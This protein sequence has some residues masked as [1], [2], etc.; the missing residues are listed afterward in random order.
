MLQNIVFNDSP[1][2][3]NVDFSEEDIATIDGI[4]INYLFGDGVDIIFGSVCLSCVNAVDDD[5][6]DCL[7][8]CCVCFHFFAFPV[9]VLRLTMW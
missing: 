1:E 4:G 6:L 7:V 8:K 5:V 9:D 3:V 2:S